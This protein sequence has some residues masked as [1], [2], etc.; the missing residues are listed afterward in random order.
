MSD[1]SALESKASDS[2]SLGSSGGPPS[3]P[4]VP[5]ITWAGALVVVS[6]VAATCLVAPGVVTTYLHGTDVESA[7]AARVGIVIAGILMAVALP[8]ATFKDVLSVVKRVLPGG[9][10]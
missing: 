9:K 4:S 6:L 7:R 5:P 8:H 3:P 1:P 2:S 10:S